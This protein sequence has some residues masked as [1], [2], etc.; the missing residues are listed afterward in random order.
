MSVQS[1]CTVDGCPCHQSWKEAD[2]ARDNRRDDEYIL[3][4]TTELVE[5]DNPWQ[6]VAAFLGLANAALVLT[7]IYL[8]IR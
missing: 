5:S 2:D 3:D 1:S 7:L 8:A 6:T 4:S